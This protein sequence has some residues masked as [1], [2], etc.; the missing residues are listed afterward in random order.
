MNTPQ[1]PAVSV[2]IPAYRVT[3]YISQTIDSVLAQNF[4]DYEVIVV[5][6]GCPDSDALEQ[7]LRPY[8]DRIVYVRKENGGPSSARN[9]GMRAARAP[10]VTLLDGD[11]L[12]LPDYL[13][14]QTAFLEAHPD[15]DV[16][17]CNGLVFGDSDYAGRKVMDFSPSRGPV[18]FESLVSCRCSVMTTVLA[19]KQSLLGVGGFDEG[20]RRAEDFD[21]WVRLV[22]AGGRI[23]Y[24]ETPLFRYRRRASSLST[25]EVAMRQSALGVLEKLGRTLTLSAAEQTALVHAAESFRTDIVY[26][27]MTQA[28]HRHDAPTARS[29]LRELQKVRWKLKYALLGVALLCAPGLTLRLA[30]RRVR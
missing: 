2:I 3:A 12:L 11:D 10:L 22:H 1:T 6:D 26:F 24:H 5:N 27:R 25:D 29:A 17:Y 9:A 15:T 13:R 20:L 28:L 19:R 23:A 8:L 30:D 14:V 18:T 16:V 7:A 4:A 21:L